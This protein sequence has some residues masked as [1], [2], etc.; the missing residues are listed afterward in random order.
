LART[1][2]SGGALRAIG[3]MAITED[4]LLVFGINRTLP[5]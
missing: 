1:E 5:E 3:S 2:Y 4:E